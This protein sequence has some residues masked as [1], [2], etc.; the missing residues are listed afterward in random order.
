M[1][2]IVAY[3]LTKEEIQKIELDQRARRLESILSNAEAEE[4]WYLLYE[5]PE[6]ADEILNYW[7]EKHARDQRIQWL[8]D[9]LPEKE[10]YMMDRELRT[11]PEW[12]DKIIDYW[13]NRAWNDDDDEDDDDEDDDDGWGYGC[14]HYY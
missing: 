3:Y 8:M 11:I 4:M 14:G 9:H 7:E 1:D 10:R 6:Y 2:N 5:E 12:T 13:E